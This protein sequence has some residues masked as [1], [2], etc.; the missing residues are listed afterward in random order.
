ME[1]VGRIGHK[2]ALG[3]SAHGLAHLYL[4]AH[5]LGIQHITADGYAGLIGRGD[6]QQ[7]QM[8][9]LAAAV[10]EV[11]ILTD[12][13]PLKPHVQGQV[14]GI[15]E[16]GLELHGL[17]GV[18]RMIEVEHKLFIIGLALENVG[19]G[20][21]FR[22]QVYVHQRFQRR[23]LGTAGNGVFPLRAESAHVHPVRGEAQRQLAELAKQKIAEGIVAV[24]VDVQTG[25][26]H[27]LRQ[28]LFRRAR[29]FCKHL[30]Q[31]A[32]LVFAAALPGSGHGQKRR[33]PGDL[34]T[35]RNVMIPHDL[36][37]ALKELEHVGQQVNVALLHGSF[38]RG[39]SG[40]AGHAMQGDVI[41]YALEVRRAVAV[42]I[43]HDL[44]ADE[45]GVADGA[46]VQMA[47][48]AKF[49]LNVGHGGQHVALAVRT[50]GRT[51]AHI[52]NVGSGF[53]RRA[54]GGHKKAVRVVAV[55]VLHKF[56][57]GFAYGRDQFRHEARGA[58][59]GH[60]LETQNDVP[61]SFLG[62]HAH[63]AGNHAQ[64]GFRDAKVVLHVKT[65]GPGHGDGGFENDVV[66]VKNHFGHG[67]HVFNMV[68]KVKAADDLVMVA[69]H[70]SGLEHEVAGLRRVAQ[71]VGGAH[72]KLLHG[73]G[74]KAVP[75]LRFGEGIGHVGQHGHVEVRAAAIFNGE[76]PHVVQ[77]RANK[78]VLG[79][80]EAVAGVGLGE[81][82]RCGVG[83]MHLP[84][85]TDVI[86]GSQTV[87]LRIG[88]RLP[89]LRRSDGG[90]YRLKGAKTG[91]G[92]RA[93][94]P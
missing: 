69:D 82:A 11:Q 74:G 23:H 4:V 49:V 67:P 43:G 10:V 51:Q 28:I 60:I 61:R 86:Q 2:C 41:V 34:R 32:H 40:P 90:H 5:E 19:A 9:R 24:T 77:I 66:A 52:D 91:R 37:R 21:F 35:G 93:V 3:G 63:D 13:Q 54:A 44:L 12:L 76:V 22:R 65:L 55:I 27:F 50:H 46:L 83:K 53:G 71:H 48:K 38:L 72:Q 26:A 56:G 64:H 33:V 78:P 57:P 1:L 30:K 89:P 73:L 92:I 62:V 84:G 42:I 18:R 20:F 15:A 29:H 75:F 14:V 88:R 31:V 47:R 16:L 85:I 36:A 7:L 8:M 80:A 17:E 39:R 70:F 6:A 58:D 68:Q 79:E 59:P 81:V 45:I 87:A 25:L 94:F